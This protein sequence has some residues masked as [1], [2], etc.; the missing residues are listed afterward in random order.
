MGSV[1]D[2]GGHRGGVGGPLGQQGG[3]ER[4]GDG[5]LTRS[6]RAVEQVGVTRPSGGRQGRSEDGR[7][8]RVVFGSGEHY[9]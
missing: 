1:L 3:G 4:L 6:R 9:P 2:A 5:A 8:V 7:G